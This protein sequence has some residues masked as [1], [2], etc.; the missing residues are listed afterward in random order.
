MKGRLGPLEE[1]HCQ[2][3]TLL[4][5]LLSFPQRDLHPFTRVTLHLPGWLYLVCI[6]RMGKYQIWGEL[7]NLCS[8]L[9][10]IPGDSKWHYGPLSERGLW[11]SDGVLPWFQFSASLVVPRNHPIIISSAPECTGGHCS[12]DILS[13]YLSRYTQHLVDSPH[14]FSDPW[15]EGRHDR[16]GQAEVTRTVSTY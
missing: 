13:R 7:L 4:I 3:V 16:K 5:F 15:C 1:E 9:T 8:E 6:T 10:L 12:L 2:E 11:K 14:W